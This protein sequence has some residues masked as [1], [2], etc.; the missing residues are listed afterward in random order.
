VTALPKESQTAPAGEAGETG[1][2]G[3]ATA[4][5]GRK[6]RR[7]RKTGPREEASGQGPAE[8]PGPIPYPD[9]PPIPPWEPPA[10]PNVF[11]Q[12]NLPES[13][14]RGIEAAG[15]TR[16]TPVQAKA[17][18]P[19]LSG[20]DVAAQS[21][22]GTGKTATFLLTIFSRLL[23]RGPVTHGLVR[24]LILSP[25]RELAVQIEADARLLGQFTGL[26]VVTVFGG[27]DYEK[28]RQ[29]LRNGCDI[30]VGTP[31]RLIDYLKQGAWRPEG[32]EILVID[33]AD[34]MLD[35][36]FIKD[37]RYILKR[38]P[39]YNR[40]QSMVF[41]ATLG[42]RVTELTYEYMNLPV[43]VTATPEKITAEKAEE[44]LYHVPRV[45][46]AALFLGILRKEPWERALVFANMKIEAERVAGLLTKHGF[47]AQAITG[48][49]EQSRRLK[50]MEEF[51]SG[52]LPIL[53]ATDVASRGLH[54]EGVTHVFNWDVPQDPE[55]YV[56][57]IGRTAR[58]GAA[59]KA[60][61]L[62][63]ENYVLSLEE[64]EK[65]VGHKIPVVWHGPEDLA[66]VD[67]GWRSEPLPGDRERRER[68]ER[69]G[70]GD[71]RERSGRGRGGQRRERTG[72]GP[73]ETPREKRP[74]PEPSGGQEAP[75]SRSRDV[76]AQLNMDF[77]RPDAE[78]VRPHR[79]AGQT[80]TPEE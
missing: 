41:S 52:S 13:V 30:L 32:I 67:P 51:K 29:A 18:P 31:G 27:V 63:D 50:I 22:T 48:N 66:P 16:C 4:S 1:E 19:A 5:G 23:W 79:P 17:L 36:G 69:R 60:V 11:A 33:E 72:E 40:R 44:V 53:V 45:E 56:H 39:P 80:E 8:P 54:V 59:G 74:T 12:Y 15:F 62:A 21:Q 9:L 75:R 49:L 28:Q 46:K 57:R 58:A 64:I 42:Y 70:E 2:T 47:H 14:Q 68:R 34:R 76:F 71:R 78:T 37:M 26:K 65:L 3:E 6:R 7:R 24:T 61:T 73:R 35:M 55:D 38:L 25:T 77:G 43:Q 10:D 20:E